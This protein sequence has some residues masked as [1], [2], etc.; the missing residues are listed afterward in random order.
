MNYDWI[1]AL[2]FIATLIVLTITGRKLA[3][4]IPAL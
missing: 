1:A 3:F 2:V 4:M